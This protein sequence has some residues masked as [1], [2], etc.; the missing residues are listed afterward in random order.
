MGW[1]L[2]SSRPERRALLA[3]QCGRVR[4]KKASSDRCETKLHSLEAAVEA[5]AASLASQESPKS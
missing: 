3:R 4:A 5:A 2:S 1:L